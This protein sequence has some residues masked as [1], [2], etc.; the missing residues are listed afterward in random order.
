MEL[1]DLGDQVYKCEALKKKRSKNGRIEYYVKWKGWDAKFNTWEPEENILDPGLI[2]AFEL[3]QATQAQRG[4]KRGRKPK[5][6]APESNDNEE[7]DLFESQLDE[8]PTSSRP[9]ARLATSAERNLQN[10]SSTSRWHVDSDDAAS[11]VTDPDSRRGKRPSIDI[12][13]Q[14]LKTGATATTT[15][16]EDWQVKAEPIE[17]EDRRPTRPPSPPANPVVVAPVAPVIPT[18]RSTSSEESESS[19]DSLTLDRFGHMGE[20]TQYTQVTSGGY[21]V[22]FEEV[23]DP[24]VFFGNLTAE[25]RIAEPQPK[26][27]SL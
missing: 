19:I 7:D 21:T 15:P 8:K 2:R 9:P 18:M 12:D 23:R 11:E 13:E 20:G 27:L 24:E 6:P 1:S 10:K 14:R 26:L 17:L 16:G 3:E 5:N 25:E 22:T 4:R